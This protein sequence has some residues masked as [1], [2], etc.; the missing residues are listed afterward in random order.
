MGDPVMPS[1]LAMDPTQTAARLPADPDDWEPTWIT[2]IRL[3]AARQVRWLRQLWASH[4]YEGEHLLTISHSEVDRALLPPGELRSA[5]RA[6]YQSD[7]QAAALSAAIDALAQGPP[8]PR[9]QHLVTALGLTPPE[10]HLA[11][12]C[13][14]AALDPALRRVFGYLL[15]LQ[16]PAGPTPGLTARLFGDPASWCPGPDSAL[17]SWQ[18]TRPLGDGRDPYTTSTSWEADALLLPG[19]LAASPPSGQPREGAGAWGAGTTGATITAPGPPQL[20]PEICDAIVAF[21][22]S[23]AGSAV[24]G[25]TPPVEIELVGPPGSG[26]TCLAA[27][28]AMRLGLGLVSADARAL[29]EAADPRAVAVRE[30]R[31]ALLEGCAVEWQRAEALPAVALPALP[32]SPLTFLATEDELPARSTA[33]RRSFRLGPVNRAERVRLWSSLSAVPVAP[34][35]HRVG[36]APGGGRD[37]QPGAVGR[38]SRGGRSMPPA[39][40]RRH[41]GAAHP[42]AA[43]LHLGRPGAR[44]PH[45]ASTCASSRTQARLRGEVLDD[46]G[47]AA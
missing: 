33:V 6:F 41:A 11:G 42:S 5:E 44:G 1:A 3:R 29:A 31:R 7:E 40:A 21:A 25:K 15:D 35:R 17:M 34:A 39:A 36:A 38:G 32:I 26:R 13:L 9:W 45:V 4:R 43:A 27:A 16:E 30:I 19:L 14:V 20:R 47:F 28:A 12:L 8:D 37:R 10:A 2:E 22:G 18:V 24:A 46:W 23:L